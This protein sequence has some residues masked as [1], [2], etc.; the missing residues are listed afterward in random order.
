[1]VHA[2]IDTNVLVSAFWTFGSP[3]HPMR[4]LRALV[5]GKFVALVS[6]A[7]VA[8]YREVL[9]RK[10][11]RFDPEDV[12]RLIAFLERNALKATPAESGEAFPDPD[13]KVFFCTAL[14]KDGAKV[15]TG[16]L[17]HYPES[18]IV[19]TPAEFCEMLGV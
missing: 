10:K 7:I 8:E 16:N 13:D 9:S 3:S 1:M 17:K 12:Q 14:A 2:V 11:F 6:D 4:V 15:V 19:V 18:P 5:E